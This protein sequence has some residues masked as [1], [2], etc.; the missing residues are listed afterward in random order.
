MTTLVERMLPGSFL[1]SHAIYMQTCAH[2]ELAVW[3]IILRLENENVTAEKNFERALKLK[4]RTRPMLDALAEVISKAPIAAIPQLRELHSRTKAGLENRNLAAHGAFFIDEEKLHVEHYW[5]DYP[6][7]EWRHITEP[8][9]VRSIQSAID[10]ADY[11]L[12]EAVYIRDKVLGRAP[13]KTEN[14]RFGTP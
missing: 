4:Q 2:L 6:S 7:R 5:Q 14:N 9:S 13:A 3:Q 8:I 10:E 1:I 12:R 11:L